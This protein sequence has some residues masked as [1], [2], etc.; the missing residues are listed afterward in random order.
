[1]RGKPAEID[2]ALKSGPVGWKVKFV[3][4]SFSSTLPFNSLVFYRYWYKLTTLDLNLW[5]ISRSRARYLVLEFSW[6]FYHTHA[7]HNSVESSLRVSKSAIPK[8]TPQITQETYIHL[9]IVSASLCS[10]FYLCF[11]T[12]PA[13]FRRLTRWHPCSVWTFPVLCLVTGKYSSGYSFLE[14]LIWFWS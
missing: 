9:D 11:S 4:A 7:C 10:R 14:D 6:Y 1:M 13:V 8:D 12:K 3:Y 2:K 5:I